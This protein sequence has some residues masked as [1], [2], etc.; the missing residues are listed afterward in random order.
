LDNAR[1]GKGHVTASA[2]MQQLKCFP[3]CQIKNLYER[4]K[5]VLEEFWVGGSRVRFVVEEDIVLAVFS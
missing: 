1:V 3:E 4:L 2:A 5:L